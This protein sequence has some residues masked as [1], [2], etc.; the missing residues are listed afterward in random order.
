MNALELCNA[1]VA[2]LDATPGAKPLR[3][4]V[5]EKGHFTIREA[6]PSDDVVERCTGYVGPNGQREPP[7]MSL[8]RQL[9][10]GAAGCETVPVA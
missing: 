3:T 5:D 1:F 6:G 4:F 2:S 7:Q 8:W 9:M 10:L